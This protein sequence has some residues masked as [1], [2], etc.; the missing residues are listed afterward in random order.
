MAPR[1]DATLGGEESTSYI[2]LEEADRMAVNLPG[3][4]DWIAQDLDTKALSLITATNWLETLDYVGDRCTSTQALKWPRGGDKAVCDGVTATCDM[5]PRRIKQAQIILAI[6][7]VDSPSSFPGGGGGNNAP[8]GTFT[9]RQKLGE[10]EI[11]F[12]Q[13]NNNVGSS[14]DDCDNPQIIQSFPWLDD[15]LLCWLNMGPSSGAG[16]VLTRECCPQQPLST[17]NRAYSNLMP[18]P[19]YNNG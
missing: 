1:L 15:Y 17:S 10:L 13:F 16:Y 6:K 19:P 4:E 11:E 2:T 3:G 5:I 7:Y 18:A 9:K 8:S 14:C 12:A